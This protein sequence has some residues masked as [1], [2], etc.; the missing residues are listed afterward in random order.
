M[1]LNP[2]TNLTKSIEETRIVNNKSRVRHLSFIVQGI[3][4]GRSVLF[5]E[6]AHHIDHDIQEAAKERR[7]QDFFQKSKLD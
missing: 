5:S 2:F 1:E 4:S 3:I 6:I 7:T